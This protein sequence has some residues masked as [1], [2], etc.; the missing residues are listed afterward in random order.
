[1]YCKNDYVAHF[2]GINAQEISQGQLVEM[3]MVCMRSDAMK[4][5]LNIYLRYMTVRDMSPRILEAIILSVKESTKFHE[6]K[7]F[8]LY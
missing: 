4:I 2:L 3:F 1:M 7:M 5:G 6:L 8:F